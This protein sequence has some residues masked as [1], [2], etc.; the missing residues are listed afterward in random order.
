MHAVS[1]NVYKDCSIYI[2]RANGRLHIF[3]LRR[4]W[5]EL[6]CVHSCFNVDVS[7]STL[8]AYIKHVWIVHHIFTGIGIPRKRD[9]LY[10]Y[11][12]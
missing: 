5:Y 7:K 1:M 8:L 12:Q 9:A 2:Y 10:V 4:Q 11:V 3:R 6:I